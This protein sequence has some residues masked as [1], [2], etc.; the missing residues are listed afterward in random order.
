M[1][2]VWFLFVFENLIFELM[3]EVCA[4]VA[5][6]VDFKVLFINIFVNCPLFVSVV[7]HLA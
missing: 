5:A 3:Y 4:V 7:L 1:V 6:A 2:V